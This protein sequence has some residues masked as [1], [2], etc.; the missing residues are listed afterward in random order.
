M[1]GRSTIF[2][3][4]LI[5]TAGISLVG[6]IASM[7]G[8]DNR[9]PRASPPIEPPTPGVLAHA[10]DLAL[11][12]VDRSGAVGLVEPSSRERQ[13]GT[14]ASGPVAPLRTRRE[15]PLRLTLCR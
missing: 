4:I 13:I 9:R 5:I 12:M 14:P 7:S 6:A 1:I 3:S 15:T 8:N 2:A 11:P 10:T